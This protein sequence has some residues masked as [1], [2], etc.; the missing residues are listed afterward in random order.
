MTDGLSRVGKNHDFFKKIE[1]FF[2]FSKNKKIEKNI[3]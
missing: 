1:F 3:F 2:I